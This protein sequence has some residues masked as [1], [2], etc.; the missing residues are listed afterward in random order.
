MTNTESKYVIELKNL[1]EEYDKIEQTSNM[2]KQKKLEE[3]Q[4]IYA[5]QNNVN[6]IAK[7]KGHKNSDPPTICYVL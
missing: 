1:S 2:I 6:L 5:S 4:G 7:L 3:A